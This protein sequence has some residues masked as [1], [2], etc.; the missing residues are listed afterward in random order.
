MATRGIEQPIYQHPHSTAIQHLVHI[1][2]RHLTGICDQTALSVGAYFSC[3]GFPVG[4]LKAV[5]KIY[6]VF[7]VACIMR[8]PIGS[9]LSL[10]GVD[11]AIACS[12][13]TH[14]L[15]AAEHM[16]CVG[17]GTAEIHT[18]RP[19]AP[20]GLIKQHYKSSGVHRGA[21]LALCQPEGI[22]MLLAILIILRVTCCTSP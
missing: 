16:D 4:L 2:P 10:L 19:T 20:T 8:L 5:Y 15:A 1:P 18:G 12:G 13:G 22:P 6:R 21:W 3:A 11:D 7:D 9:G 14:G 17:N